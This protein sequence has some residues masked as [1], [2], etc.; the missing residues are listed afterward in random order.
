MNKYTIY[1]PFYIADETGN[2]SVCAKQIG[3]SI[4]EEIVNETGG[5]TVTEGKGYWSNGKHIVN[6]SVFI[7]ETCAE[8]LN[9]QRVAA[10]IKLQLNQQS[11]LILRQEVESFYL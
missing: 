8:T 11:V 2:P 1:I 6:E 10:S 9:T 5:A 7:V 3:L 4:V